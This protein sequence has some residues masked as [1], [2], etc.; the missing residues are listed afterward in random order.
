M[1]IIKQAIKCE[2]YKQILLDKSL[3]KGINMYFPDCGSFTWLNGI[4]YPTFITFGSEEDL[5]MFMIKFPG[6]IKFPTKESDVR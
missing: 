4:T 3:H 5:L 6:I 2:S 1:I